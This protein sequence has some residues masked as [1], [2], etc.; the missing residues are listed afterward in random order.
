[1]HAL[2][3]LLAVVVAEHALASVVSHSDPSACQRIIK[4]MLINACGAT[5]REFRTSMAFLALSDEE[6]ESRYEDMVKKH[7]IKGVGKDYDE[8]KNWHWETMNDI[9]DSYFKDSLQYI[10][11]LYKRHKRSVIGMGLR[12]KNYAEA[13]EHERKGSF[14]FI[15]RLPSEREVGDRSPPPGELKAKCCGGVILCTMDDFRGFCE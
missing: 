3:I 2:T 11:P 14:H 9:D 15:G 6:I 7:K 13:I 5:K 4:Y 12:M 1:M 10:K 8:K